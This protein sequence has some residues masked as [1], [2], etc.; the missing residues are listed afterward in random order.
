MP[1]PLV[2]GRFWRK[3][4]KIASLVGIVL[5]LICAGALF[6][7][8]RKPREAASP[9]PVN[10]RRTI[11]VLG[12]KNL[13]GKPE[14]YWLSTALSEMLTTELSQGDQ[15]RTIPGESVAQ[16]KLSLSL[17]D[18][19]S[20]GRETLNRIR[21]NLGSDD[22]VLGSYLPLGD[23]LLRLDLRLQDAVA[24]ET[25]V[26]VSEKGK[27]S[28]ID[29]LVSRAGAELRAKLDIGPLSEAQSTAVKAVAAFAPGGCPSLFGR[30]AKIACL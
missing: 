6:F 11:A 17:A 5:L 18:A 3:P 1:G 23:G 10:R 27:E 16:M 28:E 25:L 21:Q 24:G 22:V 20:Y 13:S 15:L 8:G 4:L 7:H 30:L 29:Q 9:S 26:S 14:Q 2:D 12:F 19:D